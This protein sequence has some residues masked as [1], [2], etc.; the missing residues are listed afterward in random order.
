MNLKKSLSRRQFLGKKRCVNPRRRFAEA[1]PYGVIYF[2]LQADGQLIFKGSNPAADRIR[3]VDHCVFT[4]K[5]ILEAFPNLGKYEMVA[6]LQQIA[7]KGGIYEK[8]LLPDAEGGFQGIAKLQAFQIS[9]N[10]VAV[11]LKGNQ[12]KT[13]IENDGFAPNENYSSLPG[14]LPEEIEKSERHLQALTDSAPLGL[15]QYDLYP[16]GR[17][18]FSGA[19]PAA[20]RI[21]GIDHRQLFGLP[22]E[23]AFPSHCDSDIPAIYRRVAQ[24]GVPFTNEQVAYRD[25]QIQGV[26][27]IHAFQTGQNRMAVFFQDITD[28]KKAEIA[29]RDS[30]R[31]FRTLIEQNSEGVVLFDEQGLIIEWNAA[32][33]RNTGI[34]K[35][36]ALGQYVWD[37]QF[38]MVPPERRIPAVHRRLQA[39]NLRLL[40]NGYSSMFYHPVE[41]SMHRPDG[42][43]ITVQQT[44]FPI[45]TNL[46]FRIGSIL[47]DITDR[48][49]VESDLQR[50]MVELEA[51]HAVAL[52][53]TEALSTDE[54]L[55]RVAEI[56]HDKLF[57]D[58][59]GVAF[60]EPGG[61]WL[62]YHGSQAQNSCLASGRIPVNHG[63]TGVVA[64]SGIPRRLGDVHQDPDYI[65]V[66]TD[67]RSEL[68]VPIVVGGQVIGIVN[69]EN[70]QPHSFTDADERLVIAIASELG[71]A[72]EKIRLLEEERSR[73]KE[74]EALEEISAVLRTQDDKEYVLHAVLDRMM[75]ALD[76]AGAGFVLRDEF[77]QK[78]VTG[79]AQGEW[80]FASG[81]YLSEA[82]WI[83]HQVARSQHYYLNNDARSD[84]ESQFPGPAPH[85]KSLL[86]VALFV[87][88]QTHGLLYLGRAGA[89]QRQD[90]HLAITVADNLASALQRMEL[91]R[92]TQRQLAR[93]TALRTIDQSILSRLDLNKTLE[94]LLDNITELLQVDAANFMLYQAKNQKLYSA[95]ERGLSEFPMWD[96][97]LK[98][99]HTHAG[100]VALNLQMDFVSDLSQAIDSP[101]DNFNQLREKY[102]SYV[103]Y[104]LVAKGELK[105]VLEVFSRRRLEPG[106]D[107]VGLLEAL[108][109]QAAIAVNSAQLI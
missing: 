69:L 20:D 101:D 39:D 70:A 98:L 23:V 89:F 86:C 84:L 63:I 87:N 5:P 21:L 40:K 88:G 57:P 4:G 102:T 58:H 106:E 108:A 75:T 52:A 103:G 107:W 81:L 92:Q 10:W 74:L 14:F 1:F 36:E 45:K 72:I 85:I 96:P 9:Q 56:V 83:G 33:E 68:C 43:R 24:D 59:F 28:K 12:E 42:K 3:G 93:L 65:E 50:R 61:E 90:V 27:E 31:K 13:F 62:T 8:K 66:Y 105:G 76:L 30:E 54:L 71:T 109:D 26:F 91:H 97:G 80:S 22:I 48:K 47:R 41:V 46:G 104:P 29:L 60:L 78:L 38:R 77:G 95:A 19:N 35:A 37:L 15:H 53:G 73:R 51:L 100:R 25:D 18:I 2:H 82:E 94:V 7:E 55:L 17:L 11:L 16:D 6:L 49:Q 67:T 64:R 32:Q 99:S 79:L 34:S 44:A